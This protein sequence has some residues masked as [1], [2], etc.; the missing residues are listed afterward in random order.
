M[1]DPDSP[2]TYYSVSIEHFPM[3]DLGASLDGVEANGGPN[4]I[5]LARSA[6]SWGL[7]YSM[8]ALAVTLVID[9]VCIV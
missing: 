6:I 5:I 7:N 9:L 1:S 4:P 2:V 3:D 8:L